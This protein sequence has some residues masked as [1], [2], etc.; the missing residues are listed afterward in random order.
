MTVAPDI[1]ICSQLTYGLA[2]DRLCSMAGGDSK[3][4]GRPR[5]SDYL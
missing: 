5:T 3:K 1:D 2:P 4:V